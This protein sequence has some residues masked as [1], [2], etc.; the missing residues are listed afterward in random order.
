MSSGFELGLMTSN[1]WVKLDQPS[2]K[3]GRQTGVE[4]NQNQY[5]DTMIR[6]IFKIR[7]WFEISN[8]QTQTLEKA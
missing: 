7:I 2:T 1:D 6:L 8:G 5:E 3:S 4:I